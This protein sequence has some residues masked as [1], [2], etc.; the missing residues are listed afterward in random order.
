[1]NQALAQLRSEGLGALVV[2]HDY[3]SLEEVADR[4]LMIAEGQVA[5]F[6]SAREFLASADPR[7]R[8]LTAPG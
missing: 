4:V 8:A 6:G 3:G 2:S 1:V 5:F 7:I